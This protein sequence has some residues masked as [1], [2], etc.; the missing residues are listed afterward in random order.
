MIRFPSFPLGMYQSRTLSSIITFP[1]NLV[2][3]N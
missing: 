1:T 3:T 2:L